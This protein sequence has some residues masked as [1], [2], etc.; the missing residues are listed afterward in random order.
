MK[1]AALKIIHVIGFLMLV[2]CTPPGGSTKPK[3]SSIYPGSKV[4]HMPSFTLTA[5]GSNFFPGST[6]V[7]NGIEKET[8]FLSST[9]LSCRIDPGDI[10]VN[11]AGGQN[12]TGGTDTSRKKV[13]VTV[14]NPPP[15]EESRPKP[16][17]IRAGHTFYEA[18]NIS[19]VYWA[20]YHFLPEIAVDNEGKIHVVWSQYNVGES[21]E[22][23]YARSTDGGMTWRM[24]INLSNH[25]G[26]A[27]AP[28]IA[29]DSMGNI[30]LVWF[31]DTA[32]QPATAAGS[33]GNRRMFFSR[34]TSNG[35]AWSEPV[36]IAPDMENISGGGIAV[37]NAGN[38]SL[39][40]STTDQDYRKEIYYIGSID[41]GISWSQPVKIANYRISYDIAV[42][43]AGHI[44][45]A[46]DEFVPEATWNVCFSGS[47]DGG[48]SWSQP[49]DISHPSG[50]SLQPEIAVDHRGNINIIWEYT[51]EKRGYYYFRRS[52]DGGISWTPPRNLSIVAGSPAN[53]DIAVDHAGN[54]NFVRES[55]GYPDDNRVHFLRSTDN[56]KTWSEPILIYETSG[57]STALVPKIAV[58]DAGNINIVWQDF[59]TTSGRD[60]FFSCSDRGNQ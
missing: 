32:E 41:G 5:T 6:I 14:R 1:S 45:I 39:F 9:E 51:A 40:V 46:W 54:I 13:P 17:T 4:A 31:N 44:Y 18:K 16:F 26:D 52:T 53:H 29:A 24:P 38:I 22:I 30:N 60:V 47:T 7:F 42:N 50:Y 57:Y 25:P 34:S 49:V 3:L 23:Y 28:G 15:T 55:H 27:N 20:S 48:I 56:G 43:G 21:D 12:K 19:E 8:I 10:L 37:D 59:S 11:F 36:M 33:A 58:D 35:V 2:N